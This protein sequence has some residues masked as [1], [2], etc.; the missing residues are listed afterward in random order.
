MTGSRLIRLHATLRAGIVDPL[1]AGGIRFAG[2]RLGI[3]TRPC[4]QATS[5][6][7]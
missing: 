5:T 4:P 2:S 1:E 7:R 6:E 3:K